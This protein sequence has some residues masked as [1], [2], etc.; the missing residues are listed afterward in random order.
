MADSTENNKNLDSY[1]V[2]VKRPPQD[3]NTEASDFSDIDNMFNDSLTDPDVS[4]S[5]D[6]ISDNDTTLSDEELSNIANDINLPEKDATIVPEDDIFA[7]LP[8]LNESTETSP[9]NAVTEE[10]VTDSMTEAPENSDT[11]EISLDDFDFDIDAP[12]GGNTEPS[13]ES[14]SSESEETEAGNEEISLDDFMDGGFSD[15]NP[16]ADSGAGSTSD[17]ISLDDFLDDDSSSEK[18]DD[19]SNDEALD[20]DLTFNESAENEIQTEDVTES[21][22]EDFAETTESTS[23]FESSSSTE[24]SD[25]FDFDPSST[26]EI[27]LEDFGVDENSDDATAVA[28]GASVNAAA[29]SEE[30]N[31]SDFGIDDDADETPVKQDVQS[32]KKN[33][34]VDYDLAITEDDSVTQAPTAETVPEKST[35]DFAELI[36][37]KDVHSNSTF[38]DNSIL[39]QIMN[40]LS[41]LKNQINSLK[42]EFENIKNKETI[43]VTENI[44][45]EPVQ[46]STGFF[47]NNDEDETIA[48]S[49]DE[50]SNIMNTADFTE[51]D[52][53]TLDTPDFDIPEENSE[54][55]ISETLPGDIA[56]TP[57]VSSDEILKQDDDTTLSDDEAVE[58]EESINEEIIQQDTGLS[59]TEKNLEEP[60]MESFENDYV[61]LPDVD[62]IANGESGEAEDILVESSNTD[63]MNSVN[64]STEEMNQM[65]EDLASLENTD[66]TEAE[67]IPE[68]DEIAVKEPIEESAAETADNSVFDDILAEDVDVKDGISEENID[69]LKDDEENSNIS[70]PSDNNSEDIAVF[71]PTLD[72]EVNL[73]SGEENKADI[74]D[75]LKN[76]VK[77][78]LLYMDQLLE[79]LPEEKIME[80]AKSEQFTTY[81]K[82][83]SEL[84]L[85]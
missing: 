48:L 12:E 85:S 33:K 65:T 23:I 52:D 6:S 3:A 76:D 21:A 22:E 69:Y 29:D 64:D 15:P 36:N 42:D 49:G 83:F 24:S 57:E 66:S 5:F 67:A 40:E 79:N 55:E 43:P 35:G 75:D 2:W 38:V 77:S 1:G 28:A 78:V 56:V 7:D 47:D 32:A 62:E 41:G 84:G 74:P 54:I 13:A 19:V 73:T 50:L 30:V 80:F 51:T 71:E 39:D 4:E 81:K 34:V 37:E 26:E 68:V 27:S 72:H 11:D 31:L 8:D 45:E 70:E 61:N 63:L 82:L 58:V 53:S 46:E 25:S 59:M 20:I 44:P 9:D 60:D 16:G 18:E 14:V 10:P 17:E